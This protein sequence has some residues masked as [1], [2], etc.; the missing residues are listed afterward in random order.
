[1]NL[2]ET[3]KQKWTLNELGVMIQNFGLR[4]RDLY[5][6]E[7]DLDIQLRAFASCCEARESE[8]APSM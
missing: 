5:S 7:K 1:M 6:S 4:L 3:S 8:E 2:K